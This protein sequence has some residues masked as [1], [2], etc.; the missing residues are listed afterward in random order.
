MQMEGDRSES[1]EEKVAMW[2]QERG[3]RGE[4][5]SKGHEKG[6]SGDL[7]VCCTKSL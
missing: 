1:E 5:G 3:V 4:G 2:E 6:S 7:K